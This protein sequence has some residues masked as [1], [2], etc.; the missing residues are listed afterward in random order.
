MDVSIVITAYNYE[1]Y[2]EECLDSCL[3][4][5]GTKLK[6]EVIVVDDGSTDNTNALLKKYNHSNLKKIRI[7]N[8]GIEVASNSGFKNSEGKFVVRVDADDKLSE[9]YLSGIEPYISDEFAFFYPNY[10]QIDSKGNTIDKI[11]LPNF[12]ADEIYSRGDFLATGTLYSK[13]ILEKNN[14][15]STKEKNTGLENFELMIR[16]LLA[17]AKGLHINDFLFFYR[18]HSLNLS[19]VKRNH[20]INN[21][22]KIFEEMKLGKFRTNQYHPYG[23]VI[24]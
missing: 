7:E 14:F 2:I 9:N 15:Y 11:E 19:E 4:Q 16:L 5:K 21:G 23:L 3:N 17:G 20:I 13:S 1:H 24:E 18:R 6:F 8:S 22:I 10:Y 12:D